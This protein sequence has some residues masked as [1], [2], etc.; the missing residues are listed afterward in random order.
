MLSRMEALHIDDPRP[1]VAGELVVADRPG[2]PTGDFDD[3]VPHDWR[4]RRHPAAGVPG[5]RFGPGGDEVELWGKTEAEAHRWLR[6]QTGW[7]GYALV[8]VRRRHD[9]RGLRAAG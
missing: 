3:T 6:T 9:P 8:R 2:W 1:P 4:A 5:P 7:P